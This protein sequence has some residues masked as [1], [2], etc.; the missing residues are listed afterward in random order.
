MRRFRAL[1]CGPF[2][3]GREKGGEDQEQNGRN[4]EES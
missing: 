2:P 3:K 4:K 1:N